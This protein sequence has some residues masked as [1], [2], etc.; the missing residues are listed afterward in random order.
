MYKS[1]KG[2]Q[3]VASRVFQDANNQE[4]VKSKE[5]NMRSD[6]IEPKASCIFTDCSY[7]KGEVKMKN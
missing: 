2:F 4:K 5:V 6:Y 3:K 1:F 7:F